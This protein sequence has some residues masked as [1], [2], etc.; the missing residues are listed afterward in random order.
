VGIVHSFNFGNGNYRDSAID[1]KG[2]SFDFPL[3]VKYRFGRLVRPYVAGGGVLRH[4]GPVRGRGTETNGSLVT[5]T[6]STSP[7]DTAEPS[8]LRKR[9][10]P[11][12]TVVGGIEIGGGRIRVLPEFR[13]TRWTANI[14]GPDG[15]LRFA[16]NQAEFMVGLLF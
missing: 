13:Y 16:P 14:S 15:V 1:V 7:I 9:F 8:D 3:M 11:G 2:N 4:V 12:L 6:S 5:R 10:Y